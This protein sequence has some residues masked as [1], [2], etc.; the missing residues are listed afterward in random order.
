M[1]S[2]LRPNGVLDIVIRG[3]W[4][5]PNHSN[6]KKNDDTHEVKREILDSVGKKVYEK[7]VGKNPD[8]DVNNDG[9]IVLRG[10]PGKGCQ[11]EYD[12]DLDAANFFDDLYLE[13]ML[14]NVDGSNHYICLTY[15]RTFYSRFY[16]G[17]LKESLYEIYGDRCEFQSYYRLPPSI[18]LIADLVIY[19]L[20][21]PKGNTCIIVV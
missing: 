11:K 21:N 14:N 9:K 20:E 10:R 12:T 2:Q 6:N 1:T 3:R 17:G 15:D 5:S 16:R 18:E 13:I 8:L 19:E 7:L 4:Q